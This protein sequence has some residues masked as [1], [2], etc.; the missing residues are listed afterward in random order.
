MAMLLFL[1]YFFLVFHTIFTLFNITGWIFRPLRRIHLA[2]VLLTAL[3][4]GVLGIFRGWGYCPLTDWHWQVRDALGRP[5]G[6]DSYIRFL[7][8]ELTGIGLDPFIVDAAVLVIFTVVFIL[9]I[10]VNFR[11]TFIKR[12]LIRGYKSV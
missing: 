9:S 5:I 1:D 2:A 12:G 7:I 10:I 11:D 3:S 6:S 4:W 8:F